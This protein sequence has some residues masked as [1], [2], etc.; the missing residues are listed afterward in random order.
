[1]QHV[2]ADGRAGTVFPNELYMASTTTMRI[3]LT[4]LGAR[5]LRRA[6][7]APVRISHDFQDVLATFTAAPS[8]RG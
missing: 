7:D 5:V 1:M 3:A 2:T 8:P 6:Q 4:H